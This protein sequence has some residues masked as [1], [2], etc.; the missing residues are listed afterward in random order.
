MAKGKRKK[1]VSGSI[2]KG[3]MGLLMVGIMLLAGI[4]IYIN[5]GK[6]SLY[7]VIAQSP[8]K[9]DHYFVNEPVHTYKGTIVISNVEEFGPG[10]SQVAAIIHYYNTTPDV[11]RFRIRDFGDFTNGQYNYTL[12]TQDDKEHTFSPGERGIFKVTFEHEGGVDGIYYYTSETLENTQE[13]GVEKDTNVDDK[14]RAVVTLATQR[15]PDL[16]DAE[17]LVYGIKKGEKID[18]TLPENKKYIVNTK[19]EIAEEDAETNEGETVSTVETTEGVDQSE[20]DAL[21]ASLEAEEAGTASSEDDGLT[22]RERDLK[23]TQMSDGEIQAA[24][25]KISLPGLEEWGRTA[26]KLS[27][28][29][30]TEGLPVLDQMQ[31]FDLSRNSRTTKEEK[32]VNPDDRPATVEEESVVTEE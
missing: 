1:T 27:G 25:A 20:V 7:N 21:L 11:Q 4:T 2:V 30:N 13:P 26:P 9:E 23:K 6:Q 24:L 17:M 19:L 18:L 31:D 8:T 5:S 14:Y 10:D 15:K 22:Q 28:E 12:V 3:M 32:A 16:I 29:R